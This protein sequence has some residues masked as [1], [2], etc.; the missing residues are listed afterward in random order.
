MRI[1]TFYIIQGFRKST[2]KAAMLRRW[3]E[4][5]FYQNKGVYCKFKNKMTW[6]TGNQR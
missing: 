3:W 4:N 6:D 1:N 5:V 2:F